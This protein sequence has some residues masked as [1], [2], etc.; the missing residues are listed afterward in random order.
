MS[1]N[2][3]EDSSAQHH[4]RLSDVKCIVRFV[5]QYAEDHAILLPGR[6]PG[7]KRIDLQLLPS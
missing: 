4:H 6:I 1:M 3:I 5:L 7:Y 2:S